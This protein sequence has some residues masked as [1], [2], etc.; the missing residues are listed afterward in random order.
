MSEQAPGTFYRWLIEH[1]AGVRLFYNYFIDPAPVVGWAQM[2]AEIERRYRLGM[3][4]ESAEPFGM[5]RGRSIKA[6]TLHEVLALRETVKVLID[7]WE[8][9]YERLA[10]H[11]KIG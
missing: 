8:E 7:M 2:A 10:Q 1:P 9:R 11:R 6:I 4:D 3:A 5:L